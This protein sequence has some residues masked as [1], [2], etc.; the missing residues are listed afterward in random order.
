MLFTL[1]SI[2][3][4]FDMETQKQSTCITYILAVHGSTRLPKSSPFTSAKGEGSSSFTYIHKSVEL[5]C[6]S[7]C[8]YL[9]ERMQVRSLAVEEMYRIG[10]SVC[11]YD[12]QWRGGVRQTTISAGLKSVA[13]VVSMH[14]S[15]SGY[16][17]I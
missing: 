4:Y 6:Q 8:L 5:M 11:H 12:P 1:S 10:L 14:S 9:S 2:R 13:H 7:R 17:Y 15:S 16:L 3:Q